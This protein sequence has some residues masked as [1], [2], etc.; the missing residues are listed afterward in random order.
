MVFWSRQL[1]SMAVDHAHFM[2]WSSSTWTVLL[3]MMNWP[4]DLMFPFGGK[5]SM[6]IPLTATVLFVSLFGCRVGDE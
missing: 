2:R 6:F 3:E 1:L 4:K 5:I